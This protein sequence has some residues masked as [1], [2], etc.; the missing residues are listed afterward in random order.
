MWLGRMRAAQR[1]WGEAIQFYAAVNRDSDQFG[2]AVRAI[3]PCWQQQ[4]LN[5]RASGQPT[6]EIALRAAGYFEG[7]L[8]NPDGS[9]P[10]VWSE[11]DRI[12]ALN[13]A[14][15]RIQYRQNDHAIAERLLASALQNNANADPQWLRDVQAWMIVALAAQGRASETSKWIGQLAGANPKDL[16][17]VY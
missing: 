16:F 9:L 13:A 2:S 11:L 12:A 17:V 10:Q 8:V 5:T 6:S 15:I 7:V 3:A 14:R 4:L 1:N